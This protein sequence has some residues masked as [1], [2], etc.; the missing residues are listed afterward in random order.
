M[1]LRAG[2]I[3]VL[4]LG[5]ACDGYEVGDPPEQLET[6]DAEFFVDVDAGR[7][8]GELLVVGELPDFA[9]VLT[10]SDE[11][12]LAFEVHSSG[13]YDLSRLGGTN[14][15]LNLFGGGVH[16]HQ[17]LVVEDEAGPLWVADL[18]D[19]AAAVALH[20]GG[21]AVQHG[22]TLFVDQDESWKWTYTS[23]IFSTDEGEVELMPGDVDTIRINGVTWRVTAVAAYKRT[24]R[25]NA[26]VEDCDRLQD[27]LAYEMLRVAVAEGPS[28]RERPDGLASASQGCD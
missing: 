18:G 11:N 20:L 19:R 22:D 28:H 15:A 25:P 2:L 21:E 12:E 6:L 9:F 1:T 24:L 27:M 23:L 4:S 26:T 16:A 14:R 8:E 7:R 10:E 17:S 13:G 3:C 5:S